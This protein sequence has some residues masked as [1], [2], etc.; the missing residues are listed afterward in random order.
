MQL[1]TPA[2]HHRMQRFVIRK[3]YQSPSVHTRQNLNLT[4][5]LPRNWRS[6]FL[7]DLVKTTKTMLSR[8]SLSTRMQ[9]YRVSW[10]TRSTSLSTRS[11][12]TASSI[13]PLV[14]V[15]ALHCCST[16]YHRRSYQRGS[17]SMN[18]ERA[19]VN[20][21]EACHNSTQPDHCTDAH[22]TSHRYGSIL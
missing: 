22:Y 2:T 21:Q 15:L 14:A 7:S 17:D 5:A 12:N 9:P 18:T 3:G 20:L 1:V 11:R 13:T 4:K 16:I 10:M 19:T 8:V 6:G